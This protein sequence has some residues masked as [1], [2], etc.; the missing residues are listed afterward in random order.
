[1]S[2]RDIQDNLQKAVFLISSRANDSLLKQAL[3]IESESNSLV[4]KQ[5]GF[6]E[7]TSYTAAEKNSVKI[8]YTAEYAAEIHEDLERKH[9]NGQA[10]FLETPL[11]NKAQTFLEDIK[12][13]VNL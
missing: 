6:L 9:P 11:M 2:L 5:T 3:E 12:N 13:E 4:P 8:G 7:S 1:V 10:K